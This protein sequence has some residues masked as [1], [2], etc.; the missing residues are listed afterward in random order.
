MSK[1]IS[2]YIQSI[3]SQPMYRIDGN[4]TDNNVDQMKI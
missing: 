3:L 4:N 1:H 2:Y